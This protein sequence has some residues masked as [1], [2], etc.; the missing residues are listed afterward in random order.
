[1]RLVHDRACK[2]LAAVRSRAR[3]E[4]VLPADIRYFVKNMANDTDWTEALGNVDVVVHAAAQAHDE[5]R[6]GNTSDSAIGE[7][8]VEA[9]MELARQ[10]MV[11]GVKRFV[12]ISTIGVHGTESGACGFSENSPARPASDYARSKW[13]AEE[14]L[15]KLLA[16][17]DMQLVIVRAPMVYGPGAPGKF[18]RLCGLVERGFP[19]P[20]A[21]IKNQRSFIAID[22]LVDLIVTCVNHPAAA[23]QVF[24]GSDN[25]DL[26]TPELIRRIAAAM[27]KP[28]KLFPFPE[29]LLKI[30]LSI[31]GKKDLSPSLLGSFKVDISK[32]R[33][34]L[35]W[36]PRV[37]VDS[38]LEQVVRNW[39]N[40]GQ[41]RDSD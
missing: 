21:S 32:A 38:A 25:E 10:A 23:N 40:S 30:L 34:M 33:E 22:N 19:L 36:E 4:K 27:G 35:N 41:E 15:G 5:S 20:F 13:R 14:N 17:Q 1:M 7:V 12:F 29:F 11:A 24:T 2:P 6:H 9:T 8:N 37:S 26:S 39:P 16:G 31:V 28:P 3:A 18:A